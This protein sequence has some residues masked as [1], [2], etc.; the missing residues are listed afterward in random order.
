MKTA[1]GLHDHNRNWISILKI[2]H[3]ILLQTCKCEF[4]EKYENQCWEICIIHFCNVTTADKMKQAIDVGSGVS[5]GCS[6][7]ECRSIEIVK[8]VLN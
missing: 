5:G 1:L 2:H 8:Y 3:I 4:L 7:C 6:W